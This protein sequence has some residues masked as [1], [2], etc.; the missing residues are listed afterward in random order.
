VKAR[1]IAAATLVL[2]ATALAVVLSPRGHGTI[3]RSGSEAGEEH[4]ATRLI[5]AATC[6]IERWPVKTLADANKNQVSF[7][8]HR[9]TVHSLGSLTPT[10]GGQD[11]RGRLEERVYR[12]SA[13]LVKVKREADS[14][15]HLVLQTG[16]SRMIAEMPL[17]ACTA[18]GTHR[19]AESAARLTLEKALGGPVGTSW[20]TTNL[21]VRVTGVLFFD[22]A[23]GQS[24]HA[25]NYVELHPVIGF[26]ILP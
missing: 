22:F 23:H 2:G 25:P 10:P 3:L 1:L 17:D 21:H 24:G 12:V 8:V 18:G 7:V 6:G 15:Y 14:D 9:A 4:E 5:G 20:R 13:N 26:R 11:S 16:M 19:Q